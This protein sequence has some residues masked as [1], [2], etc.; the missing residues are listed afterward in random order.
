LEERPAE[1]LHAFAHDYLMVF[2][3]RVADARAGMCSGHSPAAIRDILRRLED[4]GCDEAIMTPTTASIDELAA[5]EEFVA[6][7]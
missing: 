7:L 6:S 5:T 1:R 2:G 4:M 3:Q